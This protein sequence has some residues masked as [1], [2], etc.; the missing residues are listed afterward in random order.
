MAARKNSRSTGII[1]GSDASKIKNVLQISRLF[2]LVVRQALMPKFCYGDRFLAF[3][4]YPRKMNRLT[5]LTLNF[6]AGNYLM[7]R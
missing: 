6:V 5:L 3:R 7:V 1:I 4:T 2:L